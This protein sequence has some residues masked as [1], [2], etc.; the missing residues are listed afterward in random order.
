M[1]DFL[2]RAAW[3]RGLLV[4]ALGLPLAARAAG[5]EDSRNALTQVNHLYEELE[6]EQALQQIQLARQGPR[7]AKEDATLLLYEGV[8]LCEL[9][10]QE[11]G[12]ASFKSA[13]LLQ[14]DAQLPVQVS[15]KVE[16]LFQSARQ[17]V[18][19]ELA[20]RPVAPPAA[21][22]LEL[23]SLPVPSS[24][25]RQAALRGHAWI[26]AIAGG[27]FVVAGGVSWTLSRA[28]LDRLRNNDSHLKT[29]SDVRQSMSRGSTWQTV[30]VSLLS[31][32]AVGLAT[33]AGMYL[34]DAPEQ[35]LAL[36]VSTSGTSA[37]VQGKWP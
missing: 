17:Q 24:A 1:K 6:F 13:L 23:S 35:P 16:G 28:E 15:P 10:Q 25:P 18:K 9:S 22:A 19:S 14:P 34:L 12:T 4:L 21:P 33:A 36:R 2:V 32:G 7:G 20:S 29:M 3:L 37:F 27:A 26:P 30:G 11:Q 8:I 31:A 5:E